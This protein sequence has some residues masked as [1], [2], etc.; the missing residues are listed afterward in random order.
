[1]G[2]KIELKEQEIYYPKRVGSARDGHRR[3]VGIIG[4]VVIFSN[5]GDRNY[6]CKRQSFI[7]WRGD[8]AVPA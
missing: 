2:K 7:A 1:M 3:I 8:K 6:S 5:G 4:E